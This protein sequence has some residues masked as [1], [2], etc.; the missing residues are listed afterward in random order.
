MTFLLAEL[1]ARVGGEVQ[2]DGALR[3]ERVAP[4]E[5]AG[6]ADLSFFSNPRYREAFEASRAG[7]VVLE[8]GA[9][10]PAGR[11]VLR[12]KNAYLAFAR[13][14]TL[15]HPPREPVPEIAPQAA[16]HPSAHVHP[17]AQVMPFACVGPGAEVGARS[18]LFPG[19]VLGAE[20]RVGED[21]VLYANVNVRERCVVG[22]RCVLQPGVVIG[23]DG[24][25]FA[26]DPVGED[27]SGPRHYKV[28][29]AG[30]AVVEDDVE[31]GANSCVDRATLG[32]TVVG[33]GSKIDNLVQIAH[34]VQVGPL[35]I[36]CAQVG[37]SGSTKLG[38][39]VVLAGQVGL[40]GHLQVG[41]RATLLAQSGVMNDIPAGET[42][43]G[44]PARPQR[45]WM[46][47]EALLR[48]LDELS[49]RVK[50]LEKA[51]GPAAEET[52]KT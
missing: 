25:G 8:P 35:S 14:S 44:Y 47:E 29:Q 2:G 5:T 36:L 45:R 12:V 13:I 23:A 37:I 50:A 3:V 38:Q 51:A 26:F 10:A 31:L 22:S 28:P 42:W 11:T 46:R 48:R 15:F 21:C 18:I 43:G 52:E 49:R 27:G 17:S 40:A 30:N 33:R 1:A 19:V 39:G 32:S 6:P 16:V 34:N 4:L 20:A 41:D 7:A 24:F 9:A